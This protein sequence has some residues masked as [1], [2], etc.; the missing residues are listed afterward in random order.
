[1]SSSALRP[2]VR[3]FA[4][5]LSAPTHMKRVS[6]SAALAALL[7]ASSI[8]APSPQGIDLYDPAVLRDIHIRFESET[9]FADMFAEYTLNDPIST[10]AE[11]FQSGTVE[12]EGV[13]YPCEVRYR[14]QTTFGEVVNYD[15]T[16]TPSDPFLKLPLEINID[17]DNPFGIDTI[18]LNNGAVDGSMMREVTALYLAR[19]FMNAPRANHV[20]VF[21]AGPGDADEYVGLYVNLEH[22]DREFMR[23]ALWNGE[24][25]RWDRANL[26]PQTNCAS[27]IDYYDPNPQSETCALDDV[28]P[29]IAAED[30]AE[31]LAA[32]Q[33]DAA[34]AASSIEPAMPLDDWCRYWAAHMAIANPSYEMQGESFEDLYHGGGTVPMPAG[35]DRSFMQASDMDPVTNEGWFNPATRA[36]AMIPSVRARYAAYLREMLVDGYGNPDLMEF[37]ADTRAL[38]EEHVPSPHDHHYS[39]YFDLYDGG[40]IDAAV[41]E[42]VV[43]FTYDQA[44]DALQSHLIARWMDL[45]GAPILLDPAP[46][47]MSVVP[48]DARGLSGAPFTVTAQVGLDADSAVLR[49]RSAS[50]VSEINMTPLGGGSWSATVTLP[51]TAD[52]AWFEYV[53]EARRTTGA[54][55]T[56]T[57]S[58]GKGFHDPYTVTVAPAHACLPL[59]IN[60]FLAKND[61]VAINP[62][63]GGT[64]DVLE[65]YNGGAEAQSLANWSLSNAAVGGLDAEAWFVDACPGYLVP[66]GAVLNLWCVGNDAI[67]GSCDP[68][69][70]IGFKLDVDGGEQ[71]ALW[72]AA[73][74]LV[75]AVRFRRQ[76]VDISQSRSPD[77]GADWTFLVDPTLD[78]STS[79]AVLGDFNA[80]GLVTIED[81]LSFLTKYGTTVDPCSPCPED[82][83]GNGTVDT[84]D[85]LI[86]LGL[87][88]G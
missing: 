61:D 7:A 53:I 81:V 52:V 80:D 3:R 28:A 68:E 59:V 45:L 73:G 19:K 86:L 75:D 72:N 44:A 51:V 83:D 36:V 24:G 46:P 87:L 88:N 47:V 48:G 26:L 37:I 21:M 39:L 15:L 18:R 17:D 41:L 71:V 63:D 23:R 74:E 67:P 25:R 49:Y 31:A 30:V 58:P 55:V 66:S 69:P 34:A 6:L 85:L 42:Q 27:Y 2:G 77:G 14:G 1:M 84:S 5:S 56:A 79:T 76:T 35:I 62:A 43:T 65:L 33:I 54:Q 32:G 60:E 38:I 82:L 16:N 4:H 12:I 9:W 64:P 20:R 40:F 10:G 70:Q 78:G 57:L 22:M 13:E 50:S 11:Y 29:F 8:A